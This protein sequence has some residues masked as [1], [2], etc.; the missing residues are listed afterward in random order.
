MWLTIHLAKEDTRFEWGRFCSDVFG[1]SDEAGENVAGTLSRHFEKLDAAGLKDML[2]GSME[3]LKENADLSVGKDAVSFTETVDEDGS[4]DN[5]KEGDGCR[6]SARLTHAFA[7]G[8]T[9]KKA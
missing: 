7:R 3:K 6:L 5:D 4:S 9:G 1:C 2:C 8:I